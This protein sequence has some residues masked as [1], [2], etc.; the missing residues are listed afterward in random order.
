MGFLGEEQNIRVELEEARKGSFYAKE[1][2]ARKVHDA[3][4]KPS[5]KK[6]RQ[7]WEIQIDYTIAKKTV[8]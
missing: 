2:L 5:H 3:R 6:T 1:K 4:S 8:D 7:S